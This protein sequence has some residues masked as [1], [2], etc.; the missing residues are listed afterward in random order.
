MGKV[1]VYAVAGLVTIGLLLGFG[2]AVKILFVTFMGR[3]KK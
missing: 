3:R 2:F 1:I